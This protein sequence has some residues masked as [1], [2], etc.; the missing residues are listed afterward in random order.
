[1]KQNTLEIS[2]T[3]LYHDLLTI[4]YDQFPE[5]PS[6]LPFAGFMN[7]I[8]ILVNTHGTYAESN[9]EAI[10]HI[11]VTSN[12]LLS[13]SQI[14]E[15][16]LSCWRRLKHKTIR[17]LRVGIINLSFWLMHPH[18][19]SHINTIIP[20]STFVIPKMPEIE[21]HHIYRSLSPFKKRHECFYTLGKPTCITF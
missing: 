10:L 2:C 14:V 4:Y 21:G 7:Y 18:L 17:E 8:Y 15:R 11:L 20:T 19:W 1:M 6:Q 9:Q 13:S 3:Q 5:S 16:N 12:V